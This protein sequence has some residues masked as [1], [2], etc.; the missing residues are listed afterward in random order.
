MKVSRKLIRLIEKKRRHTFLI[1]KI[2]NET[3][4]LIPWALRGYQRNIMKNDGHR[5]DNLAEMYQFL[6]RHNPAK[7]IQ[8]NH[9]SRT[10]SAKEIKSVINNLPKRR[11]QAHMVSLVN[12]TK[13]LKNLCQF[14]TSLP[15]IRSRGN[16]S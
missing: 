14:P 3:S 4:L 7:L 12:S 13:H 10:I 15:E 5:S 1:S 8:R 6:E 2:K 11:Y 9:M 16:T